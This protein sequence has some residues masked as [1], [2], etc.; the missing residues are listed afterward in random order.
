M[1]DKAK[2]WWI[3]HPRIDITLSLLGLAAAWLPWDANTLLAVGSAAAGLAGVLL[4]MGAVVFGLMQQS[5]GPRLMSFRARHGSYLKANWIGI[6]AGC[7]MAAVLALVGVSIHVLSTLWAQCMIGFAIVHVAVRGARLAWLTVF[8]MGA[9]QM[10][11][12]APHQLRADLGTS[13]GSNMITLP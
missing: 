12:V 2:N 10:D 11:V 5:T 3:E 8:Y 9:D 4:G 13:S 6:L 1:L 7:A